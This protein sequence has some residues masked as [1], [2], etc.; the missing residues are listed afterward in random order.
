[1][2]SEEEFKDTSTLSKRELGVALVL[3]ILMF[4]S[5]LR[6]TPLSISSV[7]TTFFQ[8]AA[9]ILFAIIVTYLI[10]TAFSVLYKTQGTKLNTVKLEILQKKYAVFSDAD[11]ENSF[12]CS[13]QAILIT[14]SIFFLLRKESLN[15]FLIATL[16]RDCILLTSCGG[17]NITE[18]SRK[19]LLSSIDCVD[20]SMLHL[21]KSVTVVLRGESNRA[22][23]AVHFDI[24]SSFREKEFYTAAKQLY[25]PKV[26]PPLFSN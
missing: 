20:C 11:K 18:S 19:I 17:S 14:D 15:K 2:I 24:R 1:M 23:S 8:C 9:F 22:Q 4:L 3:G 26:K 6:E 21:F 7:L 25:G 5:L 13:V 10:V 12:L 16:R